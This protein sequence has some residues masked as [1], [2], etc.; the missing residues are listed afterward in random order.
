[1]NENIA[2]VIEQEKMLYKKIASVNQVILSDIR[3]I[4]K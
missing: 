2:M 4:R 1:M 3:L